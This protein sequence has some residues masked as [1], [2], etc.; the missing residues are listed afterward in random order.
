MDGE[1]E[2]YHKTNQT[3]DLTISN[4]RLKQGGL[5]NEVADQRREKQ[6]SAAV[7]RRVQHD[8]QVGREGQK[9]EGGGG[10]HCVLISQGAA[11][12]C[13]AHTGPFPIRGTLQPVAC[14][15]FSFA[16]SPRA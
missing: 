2:R 1:L 10:V 3:L 11:A 13:S 12:G 14:G 4:M 15:F 7:L 5:A 16:W 8:L 6:D 9:G